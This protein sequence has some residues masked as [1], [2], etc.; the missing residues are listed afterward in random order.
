MTIP[1]GSNFVGRYNTFWTEDRSKCLIY[2][3]A[4]VVGSDLPPLSPEG[5]GNIG[6]SNIR[7]YLDLSFP[8][9]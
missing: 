2:H 3:N 6:I 4:I 7:G 5:R 9:L 8:V 1:D